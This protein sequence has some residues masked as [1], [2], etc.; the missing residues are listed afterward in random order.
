M[1][2]LRDYKLLR[3]ELIAGRCD[4]AV[5]TDL[6]RHLAVVHRDTHVA[7]LGAEG[8]TALDAEHRYTAK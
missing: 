3:K 4:P 8:I 7:V 2:D 1:E 6:A 5:V